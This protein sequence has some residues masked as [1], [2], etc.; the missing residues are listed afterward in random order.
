MASIEKKRTKPKQTGIK[1]LTVHSD[2][3]NR[4]VIGCSHL[5]QIEFA[6][7][8]FSVVMTMALCI[9]LYNTNA[10]QYELELGRCMCSL[11]GNSVDALPATL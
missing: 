6:L 3:F 1:H 10:L 4:N 5:M 9:C 11:V 2:E 7:T 8:F